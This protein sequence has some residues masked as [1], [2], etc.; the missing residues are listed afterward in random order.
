MINPYHAH[1]HAPRDASGSRNAA[2]LA[3]HLPTMLGAGPACGHA[4]IHAAD[5]LAV[6]G[7]FVADLGAFAAGVPVVWR[8]D[9][10]EMR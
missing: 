7:A 6:G 4:F 9:Q 10:H 5:P 8:I 1:T 2:T 3:R